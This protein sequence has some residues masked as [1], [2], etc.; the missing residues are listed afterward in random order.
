MAPETS[1][2]RPPAHEP[3]IVR[4]PAAQSPGAK[5][6]APAKADDEAPLSTGALIGIGIFLIFLV[7]AGV[8]G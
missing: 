1:E 4:F 8:C 7:L 2:P 6:P 5:R 3:N